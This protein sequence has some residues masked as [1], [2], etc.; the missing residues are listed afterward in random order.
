MA[1]IPI[2][3]PSSTPNLSIRIPQIGLM[4]IAIKPVKE[5]KAL[6]LVVVIPIKEIRSL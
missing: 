4:K 2:C 5:F 3:R 1:Q 6:N